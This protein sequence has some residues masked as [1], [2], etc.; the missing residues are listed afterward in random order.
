MKIE[1]L[2][3]I[4][5]CKNKEEYKKI[6]ISNKITG[7]VLATNQLQGEKITVNKNGKRLIS[8]NEIGAS[9]N[10]N[11]LLENAEGE[12]CIFADN[13]TVFVDNYESIIE[14]EYK[15]NKDADII[16]F[17]A[18][19]QNKNREK[20]KKIGNKKINKIN[21]MKIRTNEISIKKET[22]E[23]IR[24]N[25]IKFDINFGPGS[26]F[27][28]GEET[29][30]IADLLNAGMKIYSVNKTI[31]SSKNESSTWFSGFN[32]KFLFDQGAIFYRIYK[33][34]CKIMILQYLIRKYYLYKKNINIRQAYKA[35][36]KGALACAVGEMDNCKYERKKDKQ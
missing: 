2:L 4:M 25:N 7:K 15:K 19:N 29:I 32:E 18:E 20:N 5:N 16:I 31:S 9:K 6:L 8:Y 17:Y 24:K 34:K 12:I 27:E 3:T 30:L 33:N 22:I 23:K 14:N 21:L 11:H 26:I 35:M 28:K 36:C 1:V 13:D 10:R